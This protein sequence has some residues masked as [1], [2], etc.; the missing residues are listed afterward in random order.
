MTATPVAQLGRRPVG[1]ASPSSSHHIRKNHAHMILKSKV[2]T[3]TV[4]TP[5]RRRPGRIARWCVTN[6]R[7]LAS[8]L[9]PARAL[10]AAIRRA[11]WR[12]QASAQRAATPACHG[13]S[14]RAPSEYQLLAQAGVE[15]RRHHDS[16][17]YVCAHICAALHAK[18]AANHLDW[19]NVWGLAFCV[20]LP[21]L[22]RV[23]KP[24]S[25]GVTSGVG[26]RSAFPKASESSSSRF[27]S[28]AP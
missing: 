18:C 2:S 20:T 8:N 27:Y 5:Y 16:H 11:A 14:L 15:E 3:E 6:P 9:G 13:P 24:L 17:Q 10:R 26:R 23:A 1:C 28:I 7:D 25:W 22:T 19:L 21:L 12:Q 4:I